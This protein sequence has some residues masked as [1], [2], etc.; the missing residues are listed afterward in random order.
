MTSRSELYC[1]FMSPVGASDFYDWATAVN[2]ITLELCANY[3]TGACFA[4]LCAPWIR[5]RVFTLKWWWLRFLDLPTACVCCFTCSTRSVFIFFL[6]LHY[7]FSDYLIIDFNFFLNISLDRVLCKQSII[8]FTKKWGFFEVYLFGPKL[9]F[10]WWCLYQ[11]CVT[12]SKFIRQHV[13]C[14]D[15]ARKA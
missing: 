6:F 10:G 11:L 5:T 14:R 12:M 8:R 4:I 9:R 2:A 15:T 3:A 13:K 1:N 7:D